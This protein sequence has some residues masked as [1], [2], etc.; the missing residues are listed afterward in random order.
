MGRSGVRAP[1][2]GA[3]GGGG[4]A[5][6]FRVRRSRSRDSHRERARTPRRREAFMTRRAGVGIGTLARVGALVLAAGLSFTVEAGAA[7]VPSAP[8]RRASPHLPPREV[9]VD[10]PPP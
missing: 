5:R 10:P 9:L 2:P 4:R 7:P 8:L 1:G 3:V 6:R